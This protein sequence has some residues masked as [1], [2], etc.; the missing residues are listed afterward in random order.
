M[1]FKNRV[2][3]RKIKRRIR[4]VSNYF[5]LLFILLVFIYYILLENRLDASQKSLKQQPD[6]NYQNINLYFSKF[7]KE[8]E[9]GNYYSVLKALE[10]EPESPPEYKR[11]LLDTL[12]INFLFTYLPSLSTPEQSNNELL[13]LTK[14][15][16][17]YLNCQVLENCY[18]Y[19][20]HLTSSGD[21][22]TLFPNVEFSSSSNPVRLGEVRIP[23]G[24]RWIYLN[25]DPG[26]ETVIMIASRWQQVKLE[27]LIQTYLTVSNEADEQIAKKDLLE[28]IYEPAKISESLP[29]L[30]Y[31]EYHFVNTKEE[32]IAG[33]EN[34][35]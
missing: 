8:L 20:F 6:T 9:Q 18:L 12:R 30:V 32:S 24:E 10:D 17:Y 33:E 14:N 7:K 4:K 28:L 1:N 27:R 21:I 31:T 29:G 35:E 3:I 2:K 11:L 19:L 25:D 13:S 15:T 16:P 22:V 34:Y 5:I 26:E 23:E